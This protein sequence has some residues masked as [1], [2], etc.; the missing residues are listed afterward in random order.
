MPLFHLGLYFQHNVW[1]QITCF[2]SKRLQSIQIFV[3]IF[4][5]LGRDRGYSQNA[6]LMDQR[7]FIK[8]YCVQM[9]V[10]CSVKGQLQRECMFLVPCQYRTTHVFISMTRNVQCVCM[11][12]CLHT[13]TY[14]LLC[15][16]P[17]P[18]VVLIQSQSL[19]NFS[20]HNLQDVFSITRGSS[21]ASN[22][23]LFCITKLELF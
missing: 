17:P 4:N 12:D 1:I 14:L 19:T 13:H 20:L 22:L 3:E 7:V 9:H 10:L 18:F 15:F 2:S 6:L 23:P 8:M 21:S 16:L 5:Y 11:C